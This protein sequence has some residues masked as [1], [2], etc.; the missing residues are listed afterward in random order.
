MHQA[1]EYAEGRTDADIGH[2]RI[3]PERGEQP[4][5]NDLGLGSTLDRLLRKTELTGPQID[6]ADASGSLD[7]LVEINAAVEYAVPVVEGRQCKVINF[8][9]TSIE[10]QVAQIFR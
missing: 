2:G 5:I 8:K 7:T 10:M 1:S 3:H 9:D 6:I 4:L